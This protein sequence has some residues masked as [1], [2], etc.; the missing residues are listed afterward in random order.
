[1]RGKGLADLFEESSKEF[2][3]YD[4]LAH[5]LSADL[6][7]VLNRSEIELNDTKIT[8]KHI[9]RILTLEA[10][11]VISGP[12]SKDLVIQ[13][14]KTGDL[15]SN[16]AEEKT[17]ITDKKL[18]DAE[19]RKAFMNAP[20]AVN[21]ARTNENAINYLLGIVMGLTKGRADPKETLSIIKAMLEKSRQ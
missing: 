10:D 16:I 12:A 19:I 8:S 15:P 4:K 6:L 17:K 7:G 18:L 20:Q 21:D 13:L 2:K 9:L 14:V 5:L 3:N 11:G 1:M